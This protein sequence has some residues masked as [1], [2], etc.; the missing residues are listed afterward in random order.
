[1][2]RFT[3]KSGTAFIDQVFTKWWTDTKVNT[4]NIGEATQR[5]YK[6]KYKITVKLPDGKIIIQNT[7]LEQDKT[8]V[9]NTSSTAT[10]ELATDFGLKIVPNPAIAPVKIM[11]QSVLQNESAQLEI[12]NSIGVLVFEKKVDLSEGSIVW[13]TLQQAKGVYFVTLKAK[14]SLQTLKFIAL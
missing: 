11:W 10:Q 2:P 12:R 9:I 5:G 7:D 1:M 13:D 3:T 14:N 8:L 4:S 6:G